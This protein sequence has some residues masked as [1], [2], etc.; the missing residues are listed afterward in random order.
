[1]PAPSPVTGTLWCEVGAGDSIGTLLDAMG[2]GCTAP[3]DYRART[4]LRLTAASLSRRDVERI[5]EAVA[6]ARGA[7]VAGTPQK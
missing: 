1:V 7:T 3:D 4:D 6:R 2:E 5:A